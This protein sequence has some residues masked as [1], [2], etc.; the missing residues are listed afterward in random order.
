MVELTN[1]EHKYNIIMEVALLTDWPIIH[2]HTVEKPRFVQN[3]SISQTCPV[4][5]R[6]SFFP[7][8]IRSG[9]IRQH[10]GVTI[11]NK[12]TTWNNVLKY[13]TLK[14]LIVK[15]SNMPCIW[16]LDFQT[17]RT[18]WYESSV[19]YHFFLDG[20]ECNILAI[21]TVH[22]LVYKSEVFY[23]YM[24]MTCKALHHPWYNLSDSMITPKRWLSAD[25]IRPAMMP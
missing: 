11:V 4:C 16:A 19:C 17:F 12:P 22:I 2:K 25:Y 10:V 18:T 15:N 24:T 21:V 14:R 6:H 9:V 3:V 23:Y 7:Y 8:H 1:W 20:G 13:N 5:T